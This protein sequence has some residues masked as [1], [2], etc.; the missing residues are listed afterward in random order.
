MYYTVPQQ[1][2]RRFIVTG[3]NSGTGREAARRLALA[4]AEVVL[5]V[6]SLEKGEAAKAA[7]LAEAPDATLEVRHLGIGN[8]A[9]SS[10]QWHHQHLKHEG[11][12]SESADRDPK[13]GDLLPRHI[14]S[15]DSLTH[16][17]IR[18]WVHTAVQIEV[19][20]PTDRTPYWVVG[21][22]RPGELAAALAMLG[23]L[24]AGDTRAT[25]ATGDARESGDRTKHASGNGQARTGGGVT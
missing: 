14:A 20:D 1:N 24:A 5:A 11:H 25:G 16:L 22:R 19:V 18:P 4:G 23:S 3:A 8:S 13:N 15:V 12:E 6:R 10:H 9:G 7:I 17:S 2:G 21:S